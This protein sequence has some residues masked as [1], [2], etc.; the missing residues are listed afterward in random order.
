MTKTSDVMDK[1]AMAIGYVACS[2]SNLQDNL[3][4][5]YSAVIS[6]GGLSEIGLATWHCHQSDRAQRDMLL[7]AA[8]SAFQTRP[9]LIDKIRSLKVKVDA[10]A[11]LRNDFI[12]ASYALLHRAKD[13]V[14]IPHDYYGNKRSKKLA[15]K[16]TEGS[17]LGE[18]RAF[19]T[20]LDE[21]THRC[22]KIFQC[23][24]A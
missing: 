10:L 3:G 14:V 16:F 13:T 7:A 21:A 2:W 4:H 24:N 1:H 18:L 22:D 17:L 20:K 8:E 5:L 11:D 23:L 6:D 9:E 19:Q 12:H 15:K